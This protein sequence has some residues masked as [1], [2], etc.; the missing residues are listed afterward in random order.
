MEKIANWGR[1]LMFEIEGFRNS[2]GSHIDARSQELHYSC[3]YQAHINMLL[4]TG[5]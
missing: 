1:N 3:P 5:T 4:C 2:S